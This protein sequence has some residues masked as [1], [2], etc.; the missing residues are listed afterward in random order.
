MERSSRRRL[1][2]L[3]LG[4]AAAALVAAP[5]AIA[6][7]TSDATT[8]NVTLGSASEPSIVLGGLKGVGN[9]RVPWIAL[10]EPQN[11]TGP[12]Q[13]FVEKFAAGAFSLQGTSLNFNPL[14]DAS[15]PS[16]DFAGKGFTVP[17]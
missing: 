2:A 11:A 13:V 12:K 10:S 3:G 5:A 17:W 15:H 16:I 6:A 14:V 1:R 9:A 7:F 8:A 4:A